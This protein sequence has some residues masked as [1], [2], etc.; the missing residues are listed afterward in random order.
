VAVHAA[1]AIDINDAALLDESAGDKLVQRLDDPDVATSLSLIL[2]HAD[3]LAM[4]VV[5]VD[6]FLRR[7]DVIGESVAS[8]FAEVRQVAAANSQSGRL[9]KIDVA[10]LGDT[11]TRLTSAAVDATPALDR[12]LHSALIDP[13]TADFLALAGDALLEGKQAA[14][15]DPRGPKG[16]FGLMRVAKDPDVARGL[17]FMIQVARAF[18]KRLDPKAQG[19]TAARHSAP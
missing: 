10:A 3:L 17:G 14:E 15:A 11:V 4:A 9:P 12:L 7:A 2:D 16:V 5:A 19:P 13:Q 1:P 18:G 6:G 8:S